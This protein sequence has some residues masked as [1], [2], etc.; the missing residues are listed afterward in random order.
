MLELAECLR[1]HP[2]TELANDADVLGQRDEFIRGNQ[3]VTGPVPSHQGF[4]PLELALCDI[5]DGLLVEYKFAA[6]DAVAQ[7]VFR[8]QPVSGLIPQLVC[9]P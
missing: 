6:F 2:F 4:H 8:V 7:G 9:E 3:S 5:A 1:H